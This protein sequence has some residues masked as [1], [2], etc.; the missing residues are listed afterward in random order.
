MLCKEHDLRPKH[1]H[2]FTPTFQSSIFWLFPNRVH[3][4]SL[5]TGTRLC[6]SYRAGP[7]TSKR[8]QGLWSCSY[9]GISLWKNME[10]IEIILCWDFGMEMGWYEVPSV[11]WFVALRGVCIKV[12]VTSPLK[13]MNMFG[14]LFLPLFLW[15]CLGVTIQLLW[16][17][18]IW[19][20]YSIFQI[21]L[22]IVGKPTKFDM[23]VPSKFAFIQLVFEW[24]SKMSNGT[25]P[26][27]SILDS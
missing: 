1:S 4:F 7:R 21:Y 2:T 16:Y 17:Q 8:N 10:I 23:E 11:L 22:H 3:G 9:A 5:S 20:L 6:S 25:K 13:A 14:Y 18:V 12:T 26:C 27:K 15:I 24:S 19:E